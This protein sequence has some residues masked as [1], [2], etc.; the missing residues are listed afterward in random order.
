MLIKFLNFLRLNWRL[1]LDGRVSIWWKL[2]LLLLPLAYALIPLP[3]F[4]GPVHVGLCGSLPT[5]DRG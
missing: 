5:F 3:D 1:A 2:F 4:P